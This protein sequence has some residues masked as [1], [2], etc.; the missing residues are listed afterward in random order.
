MA[1]F[2]LLIEFD[3]PSGF[4]ISKLTKR[5]PEWGGES[6]SRMPYVVYTLVIWARNLSTEYSTLGFG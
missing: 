3:N 1:P 6:E 5:N 4:K 2:H